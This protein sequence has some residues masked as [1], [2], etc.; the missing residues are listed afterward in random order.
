[1]PDIWFTADTHFGHGNIIDHC[2]R[3]WK[4]V[5]L[6]NEALME[7]WNMY[8]RPRDVVYVLGDFIYDMKYDDAILFQ[9]KLHGSKMI[10]KGNHDHWYTK[11]KRY[12]HHKELMKFIVGCAIIR[13][14]H[15][16][17]ALIYMGILMGL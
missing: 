16:L 12:F 13:L 2:K 10:L 15:G 5:H 4:T 6:M 14:E 8:V 7:I 9:K 1:M 11:E 3:P 17:V